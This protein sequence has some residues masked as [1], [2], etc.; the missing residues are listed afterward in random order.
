MS[1]DE[2]YYPVH[3]CSKLLVVRHNDERLPQFLIQLT[4]KRL[5][6]LTGSAVKIA[7]GFVGQHNVGVVDQGSGD[8]NALL[9]AAGER[10]GAVLEAI[11]QPDAGQKVVRL[12]FYLLLGSSLDEGGNHDVFQ[13]RKLWQEMVRLEDEADTATS[14]I[15][16]P[17]VRKLRQVNPGTADTAL[18]RPV[19][20]PDQMQQR[21]FPGTRRAYDRH[22]LLAGN[23]HLHALQNFNR[24]IGL[25][26][27]L[28]HL[29][30]RNHH[31]LQV[32]LTPAAS[33]TWFNHSMNYS[34]RK[35]TT[36]SSREAFQAGYKVARK[37]T[38]TDVTTI[39]MTS[40]GRIS[41]GSWSMT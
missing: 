12:V 14:E 35:A 25:S 6:R 9:L 17:P 39:A 21:A 29:V 30:N 3:V 8:C 23:L 18:R 4:Q 31:R 40:K 32:P 5:Y 11:R 15:R 20:A 26:I 41:T 24:G 19:Q 36:G 10:A 28:I 13:G 2:G 1:I 38:Q 16:Q 22:H 27:P 7:G 34:Y 33:V 37:L